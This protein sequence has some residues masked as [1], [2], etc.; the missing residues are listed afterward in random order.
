MRLILE[1]Y[2][3]ATKEIARKYGYLYIDLRGRMNV[4][5]LNYEKFIPTSSPS[6]LK[7]VPI[8]S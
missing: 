6:K 4:N 3:N 7:L 5:Y 2:R 8:Q 1:D